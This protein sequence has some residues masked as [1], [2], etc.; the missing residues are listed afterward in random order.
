MKKKPNSS[1]FGDSIRTPDVLKLDEHEVVFVDGTRSQF[2]TIIYC[3]GYEYKYPFLSV[4]CGITASDGFAKPLFKHC[5]NINRPS[6]GFI[7]LPNLICPNQLFSLQTRFCLAF[8]TGKKELPTKQQMLEDYEADLNRQWKRG[9][10]ESKA[11]LLIVDLQDQYYV[12]LAATAG[13]E[14][15][16][17]VT[18]ACRN[19]HQF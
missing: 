5:L 16:N 10:P 19:C 2:T 6:M 12:D 15:I 13:V 3:T 9:L 17:P 18:N 8:I 7:G 1:A 4:D 11:H 14:P